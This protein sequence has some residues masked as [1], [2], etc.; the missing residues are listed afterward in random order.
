M[1]DTAPRRCYLR[2]VGRLVGA[3]ADAALASGLAV[4]SGRLREAYPFVE[5]L[6]RR[7]GGGA[8][9]ILRRATE[10]ADD[11]ADAEALQALATPPRQWAGL[12]LDRPLVMGII[13]VTPD[14][15]SDGGAF[16]DPQAAIA[17]GRALLAAGADILDVGGES[18]RPG[19]E[20]VGA[21]AEAARILPVIRAL[22]ATGAVVSV[23]T[24]RT[25]VMAA[26]LDA[27][28][29]IV[30]D[31]TALGDDGALALVAARRVPTVLMHMRG[32]PRTM[33][34]AP[35][36]D[37]PALDLFDYFEARLAACAAAGLDRSLILIDPGIGFGKTLS[38][39][40]ELLRDLALLRGLG[41]GLLLGVSRKSFIGRLSGMA[42][43]SD[44]VPGSLIAGLAGVANGADVLRVH[45]VAETI[46]ALRVQ[47]ALDGC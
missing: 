18:T 10:L 32:E 31:V 38:H 46:Q 23:D 37:V 14:S 9:R 39:N 19:A 34:Q 24:R 8:D 42:A 1:S 17:H 16:L 4:P 7:D 6:R 43:A 41:C 11:V 25:A 5:I 29:G 30:N 27:G 13:N 2:P 15:F 26:A 12:A 22:A 45:D 28:A 40:V 35:G 3:E 36:Y 47:A 20:P 44:R 21:E 33:Q